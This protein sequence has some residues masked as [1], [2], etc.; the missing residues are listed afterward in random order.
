M[1]ASSWR[2]EK[3]NDLSSA[4]LTILIENIPN[5]LC[6]L[7]LSFSFSEPRVRALVKDKY[8]ACINGKLP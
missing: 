2:K 1:L 4:K 8:E 3:E 5:L 7:S 6:G